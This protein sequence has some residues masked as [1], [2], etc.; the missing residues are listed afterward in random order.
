MYIK[1]M[2]NKKRLNTLKKEKG[3]R[4]THTYTQSDRQTH[5]HKHTHIQIVRQ[6]HINTHTFR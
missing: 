5:T 1:K 6:T 3:R 2:S 4:I